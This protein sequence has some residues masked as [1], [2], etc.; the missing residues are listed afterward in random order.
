MA[1]DLLPQ[2]CKD[3]GIATHHV[4]RVLKGAELAGT[5]CAHPL[6]GRGY[7]YDVPVLVGD[8]VTTEAGTGFVHIA[9]GHG[10]EDFDLGR[11]HDLEIPDTVGGDGTFNRL[12]AA[13]R[14]RARLQGAPIR[15][16]PHCSMPAG[17]LA[18]GKLVHSYPHSWR[19]KA[20]L[21]FRA[22]PQWFIRLDGPERIREKAL[23]GDR[24]DAFRAGAGA[25]PPRLDGRSRPDWCISRQRAW[26]VPIAVFVDT[27]HRRAAARSGGGRA[28]RRGVHGRGRRCWYASPPS[29]F[30]GNDRDPDDY[31][32]VMDIVDVW[33]ES[34]S[35]HA[36]VL[37]A[38]DLPWPADLYLEGSDQH[39]GW[40]QSSLLEA[41]GTRGVAPFKAVLTDGFVMDEQGRKMS[42]SLGNVTAPQE[43]A[44]KYGADI[45]RLWVMMSDT[46]EDLRIGPEILKQQAELYRRLRN[47]LRWL[48]GSLA[49]FTEA[50]RVP[51][52]DMPELEKWV[53]HRLTE[54]DARIRAAVRELRLDRRLSGAAQ[55]LR[56][57]SVGVLLRRAQGRDLLRP[58]RQPA[59]PRRPHRAGSS[60]SLPDHLARA[61]A[62]L[63]RRGGVVRA[64]RREATACI[65]SFSRCCRQH[66]ATTRWPRRWDDDPCASAG[67]S[68]CR[69]RRRA[70]PIRS[71]SSLQAAVTLPL[72][73]REQV[74]AHRGSV[75][76]D[77]DRFKCKDESRHGRAARDDQSRARQQVRALLACVAGGGQPTE[78]SDAVRTLRRRGRVRTGLPS[79]M[80]QPLHRPPPARGGGNPSASPSPCAEGW[81]RPGMTAMT[82][83]RLTCLGLVAALVSA[84]RRPGQQ[85]VDPRRHPPAGGRADRRCCRC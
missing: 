33:F 68:P 4:E 55:F 3:V 85:V 1:L 56:H 23:D 2:V 48:L 9:P 65:C 31:E 44:D 39:R 59:S 18:R 35:T 69:S 24:R 61:G 60:A 71:G 10:E 57:R 47:T 81:E 77:R 53:L 70:G 21:I 13:V 79:L 28:H 26:G 63:H 74:V 64:L 16:A 42:K 20:P 11:A 30:L 12:G 58:A 29:R 34:G 72:N 43:V 82:R 15:S 73:E 38:R 45:L 17:L 36:F 7:D 40:F 46:T 32:Q 37:E 27:A 75:G 76:R 6:R 8:H 51:Y 78:A 5:V 66:G 52:D 41:V 54:L 83:N 50:E 84:R 67:A 49:G 19:S 25:Q 80:A 62:V 14:R 22:T